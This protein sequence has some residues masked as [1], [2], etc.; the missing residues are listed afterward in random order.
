MKFHYCE[1][2]MSFFSEVW[3]TP[4]IYRN[5]L[6]NKIN[7]K[8][9]FKQAIVYIPYASEEKQKNNSWDLFVFH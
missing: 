9:M 5:F 7:I 3:F 8:E 4:C 6:T 1:H 2:E